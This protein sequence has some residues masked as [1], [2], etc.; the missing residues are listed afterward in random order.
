MTAKHIEFG[1]E[2]REK[3]VAGVS[4]L[5]NAVKVTLGPRGRNVVLENAMRAPTITKD[6]VSVAK[7]FE[8]EDK[9]ENMGVQIVK[10]IAM[11]TADSAGD[12]TTTATVLAHKILLEG[13]KTVSMG[14]NPMDIKRGIDKA[15]ATAVSELTKLS[16]PCETRQAIAQVATISAN[17]DRTVGELIAEAL[18]M[19][20]KNGVVTVGEGRSIEDG[21]DFVAGM[22]LDRGYLSPHFVT[23][24]QT[25]SVEL[26][27]PYIL[28][29]EQKISRVAP[30][31]PLLEAIAETGRPLLIIAEDVEG[32]ALSALA[33]NAARGVLRVAAIKSP[34]F[35]DNRKALVEDVA[36]LTGGTMISE[37]LGTSLEKVTLES[38]GAASRVRISREETVI[39]GSAGGQDAI[40][41]RVADIRKEMDNAGTE[42]NRDKLQERIASLSGGIAVINVGAT[43]ELEMEERKARVDDALHASRAAVEEGTVPGGGVALVRLV[44]SVRKLTGDNSDQNTGIAIVARALE[45]PLRQITANANMNGVS[46]LNE[47]QAGKYNFGCNV[48]TGQF[49][50]MRKMGIVDSTKVVRAALQNAAGIAGL[51]I[52]AE[53]LVADVRAE[54]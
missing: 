11:A 8:L 15:V 36:A 43:T 25:M 40:D 16:R 29:H 6:G 1:E 10:D 26:D 39:V 12:G 18:E 3:I 44:E 5:A 46:I 30:L 24:Q 7:G 52:T 50:N 28:L 47:I 9:F 13:R 21:I 37:A 27:Q 32:E 22:Q 4:K 35:G 2:A 33:L 31:L 19:V 48:A 34:G 51:L 23:D 45:E 42:I 14:A 54:A 17:S 49:G 41:Q 38:L 53:C 20:G